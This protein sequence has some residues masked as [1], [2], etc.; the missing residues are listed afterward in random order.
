MQFAY[1]TTSPWQRDLILFPENDVPHAA[2]TTE[3]L[4]VPDQKEDDEE[5]TRSFF[6]MLVVKRSDG[7]A[8]SWEVWL[9]RE[10]AHD[11]LVGF[12]EAYS[13]REAMRVAEMSAV[14]AAERIAGQVVVDVTEYELNRIAK[15]A[16]TGAR[17]CREKE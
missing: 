10:D 16:A 4:A 11:D 17:Q 14:H 3:L 7:F 8:W 12:G 15:A 9:S 5:E 1:E 6:E 13:K 2:Q